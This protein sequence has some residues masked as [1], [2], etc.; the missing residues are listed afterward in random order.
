M[1]A[2][3]NFIIR[4]SECNRP[5]PSSAVD[6]HWGRSS[7]TRRR[8][9]SKTRVAQSDFRRD[10]TNMRLAASS[11]MAKSYLD[12]FSKCDLLRHLPAGGWRPSCPMFARAGLMPAKFCSCRRPRR[13]PVYCY[14]RQRRCSPVTES[15]PPA[16]RPLATLGE[17]QAFGEMALLMGGP[18]TA[19]IRAATKV[20]LLQIGKDDFEQLAKKAGPCPMRFSNSAMSG[21]STI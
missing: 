6:L 12:C 19:T 1:K 4:P 8:F 21:P 9:F 14:P 7:I 13:R 15:G 18:R 16:S 2:R 5:G 3:N 17:G 10:F 11:R 20:E